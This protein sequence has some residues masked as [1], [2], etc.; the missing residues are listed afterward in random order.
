ML[1]R[2]LWGLMHLRYLSLPYKWTTLFDQLSDF[3]FRMH[4]LPRELKYCV[5]FYRS[6]IDAVKEAIPSLWRLSFLHKHLRISFHVRPESRRHG[7]LKSL[8]PELVD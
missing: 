2:H 4:L 6:R 1:A 8:N 5:D 7:L 3:E